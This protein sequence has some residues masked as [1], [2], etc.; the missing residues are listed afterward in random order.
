MDRRHLL[1]V[2]GVA[3]L[4]CGLMACQPADED[5]DDVASVAVGPVSD[6]T[7][8][9]AGEVE[10]SRA[11]ADLVGV[12]GSGVSG[13]VDVIGT[14]SGVRIVIHAMGVKPA[15]PHGVHVHETGECA[16]PDFSSAGGHLNPDGS[17]HACPPSVPR[18]AG[19]LGNIEIAESGEG[20]LE[21]QTDLLTVPGGASSLQG[22]AI[23]LHA[24]ADD[25]TTQP[26]GDSGDPLACGVFERVNQ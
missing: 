7:T 18:H 3:L 13:S 17:P 21:V 26:S 12:P 23:V 10:E 9:S 22:R 1:L 15:G 16:P 6:A 5:S 25:C 14:L 11:R 20:H 2:F 4:T 19:D 8:P 24:G